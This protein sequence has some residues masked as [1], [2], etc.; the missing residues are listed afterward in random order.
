MVGENSKVNERFYLKDEDKNYT[1]NL[2]AKNGEIIGRSE[3]YKSSQGR[4]NG[5]ESVR[6][7][8]SSEYEDLT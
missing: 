2:K 8:S 5:I 1:F 4:L 7:N 3:G 6:E